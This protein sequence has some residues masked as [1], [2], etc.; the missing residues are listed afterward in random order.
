[1]DDVTVPDHGALPVRPVFEPIRIELRGGHELTVRELTAADV[2]G[3]RALYEG[4]SIDDIHRRFFSTIRITD[5]VVA[6]WVHRCRKHGFGLVAVVD[7]GQPGA[8]IVADAGYVLVPDGNGELAMT[9]AR[10]R[11]GWLGPYLLDTLV[12]AAAE[13][14]VANLEADILAENRTMLSLVRR[15]GYVTDGGEDFS[16][17]H[18]V[19]GTSNRGPVW[20]TGGRGPRLLV[21]VPGSHWSGEGRA[22]H[23]G[24][25]VLACDR[26]GEG[27][28]ALAGRPC[29]LAEGAD[30]IVVALPPGDE[31]RRLLDAHARLH[32]L[33]PVVVSPPARVAGQPGSCR[34]ASGSPSAELLEALRTV[35]GAIE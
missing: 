9:V 6:R 21:E 16:V 13:R 14:G 2:A 35:L 19:I 22:V 34:L 32:S 1:V 12:A 3:I 26:E 5:T 27:C 29:P 25:D 15:R 28:P 11:R 20:P 31:R 23:A 10:E 7:D 24:F 4:L 18:V 17:L 33:V 30:A 8:Q